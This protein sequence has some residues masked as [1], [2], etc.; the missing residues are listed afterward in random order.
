MNFIKKINSVVNLQ[1]NF[2][3]K[4]V[5]FTIVA[6]L[7]IFLLVS[8]TSKE[9]KDENAQ[10]FKKKR[11][12]PSAD[13]RAREAADKNSIFNSKNLGGGSGNFEFASSNVLWRA[14]LEA[15]DGLPLSNSDYSGGVII[16]DWYGDEKKQIKITVRFLSNELALTSLKIISHTRICTV[17][18]CNT[19]K[20]SE[21]F[22]QQIKNKIIN[23]ARKLSI[24]DEENKKK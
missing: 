11:I 7:V 16:T 12:N 18:N 17:N 22:N 6:F 10:I 5:N 3:L 9:A 21:D 23:Q 20:S 1:Q 14:S 2:F 4:S 19:K 24:K 13:E 15:L 8:C